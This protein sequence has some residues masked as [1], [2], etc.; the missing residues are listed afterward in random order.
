M[1]QEK[2]TPEFYTSAVGLC[3]MQD[4]PVHCAPERQNCYKGRDNSI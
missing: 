1:A 4:A 2:G 3:W